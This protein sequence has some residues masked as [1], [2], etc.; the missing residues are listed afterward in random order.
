MIHEHLKRGI[1]FKSGDPINM[2]RKFSKEE[3]KQEIQDFRVVQSYQ[4]LKQS[5][6]TVPLSII[7]MFSCTVYRGP[8]SLSDHIIELCICMYI[9]YIHF[10]LN[11]EL[12]HCN[13][14]TQTC[15]WFNSAELLLYTYALA[16]VFSSSTRTPCTLTLHLLLLK[17][18]H[19]E[20]NTLHA[21]IRMYNH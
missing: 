8:V 14:R 18:I 16:C 11:L 17:C 15:A 7:W 1:D 10:F 19:F 21:R 13:K 6:L 2:M 5:Q 3:L 4:W 9:F 12:A 20:I